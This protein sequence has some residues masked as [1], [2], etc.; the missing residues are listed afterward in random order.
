MDVAPHNGLKI[1]FVMMTTI[2]LIVT[3]M[4][5]LVATIQHLVGTASV[6]N[7]CV[8]N[9]QIIVIYHKPN[10]TKGESRKSLKNFLL[11][12][13]QVII[14]FKLLLINSPR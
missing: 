11:L 6:L 7:V 8:Y 13:N 1:N 4:E 3:M 12:F 10:A 14:E 5:E 9:F 2:M